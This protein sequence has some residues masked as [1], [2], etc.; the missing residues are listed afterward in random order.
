[1]NTASKILVAGALVFSFA[2]P[3]M[4]AETEDSEGMVY[5]FLNGKM[6]KAHVS[7]EAMHGMMSHFR[8]LRSGTMIY[9]SGG[10]FYIAEDT[11]MSGGKMMSTMIFGEDLGAGSQR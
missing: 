5:E 1:M 8:A 7:G 10:H 4:A 11:R 3:V 6:Y 9:S 2:A